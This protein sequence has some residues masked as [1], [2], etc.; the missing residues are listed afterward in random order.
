MPNNNYLATAAE[1]ITCG[2]M[3]V[4]S[5]QGMID[6]GTVRGLNDIDSVL[7][8]IRG[9]CSSALMDLEKYVKSM[10][11]PGVVTSDEEKKALSVM[12]KN[13]QSSAD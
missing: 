1:R 12:V 8:D 4:D 2:Y 3:L 13:L 6:D 9:S 11:E 10:N 5:I 7:N